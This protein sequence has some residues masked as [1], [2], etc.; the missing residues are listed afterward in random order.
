MSMK[1]GERPEETQDVVNLQNYLTE[2]R[3][4]KI[5]AIKDELKIV[6]QRVEFL[7]THAVMNGEFFM[8]NIKNSLM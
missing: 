5:F 8:Y 6:Y 7:L 2:C 3:D 4:E 1:V